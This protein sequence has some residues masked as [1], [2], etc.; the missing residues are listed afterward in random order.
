MYDELTYKSLLFTV[1]TI[2]II[3]GGTLLWKL[4]QN[5]YTIFFPLAI[6]IGIRQNHTGFFL[7]YNLMHRY[8]LVHIGND[9]RGF[10]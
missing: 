9:I 3:I 5:R 7:D 8:C 10:G 1:V 6:I 4:L 2:K